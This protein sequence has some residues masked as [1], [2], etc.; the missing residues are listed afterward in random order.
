MTVKSKLKTAV[1]KA[2]KEGKIDR[3]A[4]GALIEAAMKLADVLDDPDWPMLGKGIDNVT[5]STFLKYCETLH[6][7]PGDILSKGAEED[8]S[9]L[10]KSKWKKTGG[11]ES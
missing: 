10:G 4:Q 9:I 7:T 6:L 11:E 2:I 3:K 8:A 1:N 5:P